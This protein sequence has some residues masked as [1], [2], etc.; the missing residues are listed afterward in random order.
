MEAVPT[1][2]R[3]ALVAALERR[4]PDADVRWSWVNQSYRSWTINVA[5]GPHR[6]EIAWGPLSG[7]GATDQNNFREEANPF[8]AFD[9]PLD[10]KEAAVEFVARVLAT[11]VSHNPPMQRTG[12]AGIVSVVRKLLRRGSGR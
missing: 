9:W 12:A 3:D 11:E 4:F 5:S 10:S 8:G 7:F 6:I 2:D 1:I